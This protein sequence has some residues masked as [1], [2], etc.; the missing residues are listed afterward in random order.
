MT[1]GSE[2]ARA[3]LELMRLAAAIADEQPTALPEPTEAVSAI[4][5]ANQQVTAE[6]STTDADP[7]SMATHVRL[8]KLLEEQG[9]SGRAL[10]VLEAA[11]TRFG[12]KP[13]IL[14]PLA[15]LYR[16][17]A[18]PE[19]AA[20]LYRLALKEWPHEK[21]IRQGLTAAEAALREPNF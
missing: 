14:V 20:P 10:A 4:N 9:W 8:A 6:A 1:L 16:R 5:P 13:E 17:F 18:R 21:A 7:T 12:D 19:E 15:D 2:E 3:K 11:R